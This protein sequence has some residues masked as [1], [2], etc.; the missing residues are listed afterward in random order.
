[1]LDQEV[2]LKTI[3]I[4]DMEDTKNFIA[5]LEVLDKKLEHNKYHKFLGI[6]LLNKKETMRCLSNL[7]KYGWFKRLFTNVFRVVDE[8]FVL[9]E[10]P[11][12]VSLHD[13]SILSLIHI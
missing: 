11:G 5:F 9:N 2:V 4:S 10:F 3:N 6:Y 8:E 1:M 7:K 12:I 13:N